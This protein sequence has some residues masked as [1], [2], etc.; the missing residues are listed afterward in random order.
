MKT[1]VIIGILIALL[2]LLGGLLYI[3]AQF[4]IKKLKSENIS[5]GSRKAK[6]WIWRSFIIVLLLYSLFLL[7]ANKEFLF[8]FFYGPFEIFLVIVLVIYFVA[9][10]ELV[11]IDMLLPDVVQMWKRVLIEVIVFVLLCTLTVVSF[12]ISTIFISS[13]A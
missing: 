3:A 13:F 7:V 8:S 12:N 6:L 2:L 11:V 1:G 10:V 5:L 4:I 9:L